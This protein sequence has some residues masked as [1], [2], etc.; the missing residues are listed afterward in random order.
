[1][2]SMARYYDVA[3]EP[4][5]Q[6]HSLFLLSLPGKDAVAF[7]ATATMTPEQRTLFFL[8]STIR[9]AVSEAVYHARRAAASQDEIEAALDRNAVWGKAVDQ[10]YAA[11]LKPR[12]TMAIQEAIA[13]GYIATYRLADG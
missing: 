5:K 6:L 10:G 13:K 7:P 9:R 3:H 1:M 4:Y 12:L 8:L 2:S 11:A